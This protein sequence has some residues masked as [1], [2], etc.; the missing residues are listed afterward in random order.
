MRVNPERRRNVAVTE[1]FLYRL[2]VRPISHEEARQRMAQIVKPETYL[3]VFPK[4]ARFDHSRA[5]VIFHQHIGHAG[6]FA[7][8]PG[9]CKN[10][11]G[12]LTVSGFLLPLA[13]ETRKAMSRA[14]ARL[15]AFER[16]SVNVDTLP[17]KFMWW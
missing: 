1:H 15:P 10:P 13:N 9:A 14:A 17:R 5:E 6:L 3:R 16:V 8:K 12:W 2:H 7:L 11:V 4:H